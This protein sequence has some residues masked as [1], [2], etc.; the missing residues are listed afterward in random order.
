MRVVSG[1]SSKSSR[2][3]REPV[4]ALASEGDGELLALVQPVRQSAAALGGR[5]VVGQR[6]RGVAESYEEYIMFS[7]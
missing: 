7:A 6:G 4:G 3:G 2:E 5:V 1:S